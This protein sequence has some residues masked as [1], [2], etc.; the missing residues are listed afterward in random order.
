MVTKTIG[1]G[2]DYATLTDAW[3]S[4][5][6]DGNGVNLTDDYTFNLISNILETTGWNGNSYRC[7]L[8]S[9]TVYF[10]NTGGYT[11]TWASGFVN[12]AFV[13][14]NGGNISIDGLKFSLPINNGSISFLLGAGTGTIT[15]KNVVAIGDLLGN[16]TTAF[17]NVIKQQFFSS[18]VYTVNIYNCKIYGGG[19]GISLAGYKSGDNLHLENSVLYKCKI[20]VTL[21]TVAGT[22]ISLK[23][24]CSFDCTTADYNIASGTTTNSF[25]NCADKD[26]SIATSGGTLSGNITG[27]TTAEFLSVTTSS[28]NFLLIDKNSQLFNAG[29]QNISAFN[30]SDINGY[31]RPY[32]SRVS[33]GVNEPE[34]P[35]VPTFKKLGLLLAKQQTALGT[36]QSSLTMTDQSAVEDS[37]SMDYKK[38]FQE[39]NIAQ[40]IFGQ[41][42]MVAG[43]SSI[44]VKVTLPI[45]PT[46][47]ATLPNVARYLNCSGMT[48]A[49]ATSKHSW[50]PSSDVTADWKDMT[51]HSYTGE[52]TTSGGDSLLT[53]AHSA[54]FDVEISGEVGKPVMATF[55][56]KAVPDG[57][58]AAT[59]Y[60][61]GTLTPLATVPPAV[62]KNATQTINGISFNILK[63][64]F[65]MGNDVQFVKSMGDDSGHLQSMITGRKAQLTATVY[66]EDQSA[67]NP[68]TGM[69]AGTLATTALKFGNATDNLISITSASNKSQ[70]VDAKQGEDNRLVT[71]ELTVA[72]V[73]NNVT[74]AINDA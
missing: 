12:Y 69:A 62:L 32:N 36:K 7:K 41:P 22:T 13:S 29:T 50:T 74:L 1:T 72:F 26:N 34:A 37:F 39:Q 70:I 58:P 18:A 17:I 56:G 10:T 24:V 14:N 45:I 38:E 23:N 21:I 11:I 73:D 16:I 60:I 53:K 5:A 64:N 30:T 19:T 65:K 28:S 20:G 51:L 59:N 6:P 2:G 9:H 31:N 61:S 68:L 67:K 48:Y 57:V 52:K 27:I 4:V 3:I 15:V 66:M 47:S 71:W 43:V 42:Q 25:T 40:A 8:N 44:D 46:G 54:M 35:M 33:I 63:F 49:L 55:T